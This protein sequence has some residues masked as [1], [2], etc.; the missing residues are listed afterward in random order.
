[1]KYVK[2]EIEVIEVK[3]NIFMAGS[4]GAPDYSTAAAALQSA[5]GGFSGATNNFTCSS[6][7]GYTAANPPTQ[8]VQVTIGNGTYTYVYDYKGN[9]WKLHK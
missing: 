8:N 5:C 1:M 9:H 7:G 6:F 3:G 4:E 2:P